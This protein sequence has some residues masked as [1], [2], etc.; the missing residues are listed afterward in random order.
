MIITA[1]CGA[2]ILPSYILLRDMRLVATAFFLQ[3]CVGGIWGPIPI[4]LS[5]LSPPALRATLVGLTYQLGNLASSA[6]ATIQA[7][8][9]QRYPIAPL[10]GVKRYDYGRV[11]GIFMGAVWV[12]Q[13]IFLFF[14]PEMSEEERAEYAASANELEQ[15]RKEGVSLADIGIARAKTNMTNNTAGT[16]TG[17]KVGEAEQIETA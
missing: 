3:F 5:E 10:N 1:V 12:Y 14:G 6:S 4:H 15:M 13:I 11:I 17:E 9:G 2:A 8:I 7:E 16:A